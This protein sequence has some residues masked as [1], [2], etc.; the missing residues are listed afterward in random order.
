MQALHQ[1]RQSFKKGDL[2]TA[3]SLADEAVELIP[4]IADAYAQRARV[5]YNIGNEEAA[6]RA[7]KDANRAFRIDSTLDEMLIYAAAAS[8]DLKKWSE[9][10]ASSRL[11]L[12]RDLTQKNAHFLL[13]WSLSEMGQLEPAIVHLELSR[14]MGLSLPRL[15]H[16]AAMT[17]L[18]YDQPQN[19][20]ELCR[21]GLQR[22]P[23]DE[24]MLSNACVAAMEADQAMLAYQ[25]LHALT[26]LAPDWPALSFLTQTLASW[27]QQG[28]APPPV[29]IERVEHIDPIAIVECSNCSAHISMTDENQLLCGGCGALLKPSVDPCRY[30]GSE[31]KIVP[32][33]VNL[34]C[35]FCREGSLHYVL[36]GT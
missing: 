3:L 34:N 25:Y 30:C 29:I 17:Y 28:E 1:S 22:F 35:P 6:E 18:R 5:A 21:Q 33:L 23:N 36:K 4:D 26:E 16:V 12:E 31:G 13:G 27:C 8:C 2:E 9:A 24:T 14:E 32:R 11:A 7:L 10:A 15:Y 20:L 19:G